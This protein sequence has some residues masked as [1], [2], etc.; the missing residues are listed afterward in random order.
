MNNKIKIK[1]AFDP[2]ISWDNFYFREFIKALIYDE[3][4]YEVFL[5]TTNPDSDF[6]SAVE[7]ESGISSDNVSILTTN[8]S[9]AAR[10]T[11]LKC[12]IYLAEDNVLVNFINTTIPI[13]LNTNNVVGCQ[14]LVMNN[15]V[16]PY[17]VQQMFI[18][19]FQFWVEQINKQY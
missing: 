17:K 10:L 18:T 6:I 3:E 11:T 13:Q 15:I 7:L 5:V 1:L 9:V 2:T 16:D 19:K 4:N 12:L 8:S 14:A